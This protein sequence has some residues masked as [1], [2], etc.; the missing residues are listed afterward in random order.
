[1]NSRFY[2]HLTDDVHL[3]RWLWSWL[4]VEVVKRKKAWNFNLCVICDLKRQLAC[5][6]YDQMSRWH[7]YNINFKLHFC[8][9]FTG[10]NQRFRFKAISSYDQFSSFQHEYFSSF[11]SLGTNAIA[12]Q[13]CWCKLKW[14]LT[15]LVNPS[16]TNKVVQILKDFVWTSGSSKQKSKERKKNVLISFR[17]NKLIGIIPTVVSVP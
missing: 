11:L 16:F 3:R 13:S 1:M 17:G 14:L 15:N 6:L 8:A 9:D 12:G 5:H 10:C 7:S 4:D 2:E